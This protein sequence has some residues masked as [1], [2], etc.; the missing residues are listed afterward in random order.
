MVSG[1]PKGRISVFGHDLR[2]LIPAALGPTYLNTATLGPTPTPASAAACA[3]ELKWEEIG[4]GHV[5]YYL[6][7]RD[8]A[9][10]FAKRI[11]QAMPRGT[12]SLVENNSEAILRV[13][14]GLSWDVGDEL[15]TTDHEHPSLLFTIAS[16]IR[17]FGIKVKV[18]TVDTA[19]PLQEQLRRVLSAKTKLVAMSHVSHLTGWQLPVEKLAVVIHKLNP[20]T[21]FLVDGAQA[22][23]N[24]PVHPF[25][26]GADF[27]VFCGHKWM[28]APPGWAGLWVRAT[29]LS[30]LTTLWPISDCRFDAHDLERGMWPLELDNGQGLEFGSRAWPRVVGW[31]ITWDYFE[32]EG[33]GHQFRYQLMLAQQLVRALDHVRGFDVVMPPQPDYRPS[34]LVTIRSQSWGANLA[35]QLWSH[36][37]I[38][39]PVKEYQGVRIA[40]GLFNTVEDVNALLDALRRL[41]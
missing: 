12:V 10:Q 20:R 3:A 13:L 6:E 19:E 35:Q 14:W 7:A 37:I 18:L 21:R 26:S 28:L 8:K 4:P 24:I 23:G 30:E 40:F 39:K 36:N 17:R 2:L 25:H 9:R 5:P 41:P 38:V 16:L 27:Y 1:G 31:S 15:I 33:F 22:L 11:E 29:R 32:E 34:A